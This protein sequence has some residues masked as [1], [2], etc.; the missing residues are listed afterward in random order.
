MFTLRFL[1]T[2]G[3]MNRTEANIAFN[4]HILITLGSSK[5]AGKR[6]PGTHYNKKGVMLKL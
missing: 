5:V 4:N 1:V 6:G 3:Y 2:V